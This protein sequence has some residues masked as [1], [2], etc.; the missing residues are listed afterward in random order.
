VKLPNRFYLDASALTKRYAPEPGALI[1]DHLFSRVAPDRIF[2]L[3]LGVAEVVSILVRKRNAKILSLKLVSQAF[4]DFEA[5]II[6]QPLTRKLEANA[7]L[8]NAALPLIR[9]HS[10]NATDAILLRSALDLAAGLRA[11]GDDLVLVASDHR[12]LRAAQAEG[13]LIFNP[14]TQTTADL[15]LL[16]I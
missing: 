15:D 7:D 6:N 12:L 4:T 1:I 13:L 3:H 2:V 16:L 8:I 9:R 11:S 10:I 14:E 5:E